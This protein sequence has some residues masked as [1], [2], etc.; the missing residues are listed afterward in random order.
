MTPITLSLIL[1]GMTAIGWSNGVGSLQ[2][3]RSAKKFSPVLAA[4]PI[5]PSPDADGRRGTVLALGALQLQVRAS[6][7]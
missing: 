6:S 7:R 3:T 5:M 2:A 1:S 4:L